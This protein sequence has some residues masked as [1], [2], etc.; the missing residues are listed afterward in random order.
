MTATADSKFG[1]PLHRA[2]DAAEIC[3]RLAL[4]VVGVHE[5]AGKTTR[6]QKKLC[7]CFF[8]LFPPH[9][10]MVPFLTQ[11]WFSVISFVCVCVCVCARA[12]VCTGS[13]I[14]TPSTFAAAATK[15]V[16]L[17][18]LF[19]TVRFVDFGGG[20]SV[21]YDPSKKA[22]LD[23][24]AFASAVAGTMADLPFDLQYRSPEGRSG[25]EGADMDTSTF[26]S[27]TR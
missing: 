14:D 12:R 11:Q 22:P 15:L 27:E 26:T 20:L 10:L 3:R 9:C 8:G 4:D 21:P 16:E 5:H 23:L 25:R 17:L 13:G 19:P 6:F 18:P 7:N 24:D 2:A 1:I